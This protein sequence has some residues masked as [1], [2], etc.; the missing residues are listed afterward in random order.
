KTPIYQ[1]SHVNYSE[2]L[3]LAKGWGN[4]ISDRIIIWRLLLQCNYGMEIRNKNSKGSQA[5]HGG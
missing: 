1:K 5:H 3:Q 2:L 4:F